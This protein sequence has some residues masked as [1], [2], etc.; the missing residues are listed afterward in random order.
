[1]SILLSTYDSAFI[2]RAIDRAMDKLENLHAD[3]CEEYE[4]LKEALELL[5]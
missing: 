5:K 1:M 3:E 2:E 4:D